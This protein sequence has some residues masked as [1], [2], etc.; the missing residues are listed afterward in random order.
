V[1]PP[2]LTTTDPEVRTGMP[3]LAPTILGIAALTIAY[4]PDLAQLARIWRDEPDYSHGFLVPLVAFFIARRR[5][6][7]GTVDAKASWLGLAL[8]AAILAARAYFFG[9]GEFWLAT[10]TFIP[11]VAA[12]TL[13]VGGLPLLRRLWPAIAFLAFMLTV[14]AG[15]QE[16]LS[17][18]LQRIASISS[19]KILRLVGIWVVD[20]GNVLDLGDER[21]EVATACNGLAMLTSL[22]AAVAAIVLLL[23]ISLSKRIVL[24]IS[25]LPI[26]VACNILRITATAFAYQRFGPADGGKFAHDVAGFLMMPLALVLIG[27]EMAWV[28]WIVRSAPVAH[29]PLDPAL[30]RPTVIPR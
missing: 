20:E 11:A 16:R 18:P 30:P 28:S 1:P 26:A 2:R 5:L 14:P 3:R 23:P 12:V 9:Q 29:E 6:I 24:L 25:A 21:L 15:V 4:G 17:R 22:A 7:G 10:A 19:G 27:L 8:L 13:A